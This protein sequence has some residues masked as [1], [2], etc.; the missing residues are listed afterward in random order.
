M[1]MKEYNY[2]DIISISDSNIQFKDGY[3]VNF[4]E[5]KKNWA[6]S[7]KMMLDES[8]CVG[9]RNIV[10]NTP[11]FVFYSD[12]RTK[13]IFKYNGFLGKKRAKKSFVMLQMQLNNLGYSTYDES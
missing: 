5:C 6:I 8:S 12:N 2:I 10:G 9:L 11:Y 4:T 3:I 1:N 13:V 7:T